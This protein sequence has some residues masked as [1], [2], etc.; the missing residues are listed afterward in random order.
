[1]QIIEPNTFSKTIIKIIKSRKIITNPRDTVRGT[2]MKNHPSIGESDQ[3]VWEYGI[4]MHEFKCKYM[5]YIN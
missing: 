3:V 2:W 5:P 1:M 4:V